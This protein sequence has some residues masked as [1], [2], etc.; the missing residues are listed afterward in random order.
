MSDQYWSWILTAVGLFGFILAGKK[1]W[2][3][4]YVNIACQTLWFTYAIVTEQ[5]GFIIAALAYTFVFTKNA[6][7]WTKEH[8]EVQRM[9]EYTKYDL[10]QTEA[11]YNTEDA[12]PEWEPVKGT[13]ADPAV[14]ERLQVEWEAANPPIEKED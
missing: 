5:W 14:M 8:R 10:K 2:W 6:I 3:C 13:L 12:N 1:I 9:I 11:I 7:S 4:W